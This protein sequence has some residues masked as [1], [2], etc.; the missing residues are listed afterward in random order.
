VQAHFSTS[1]HKYPEIAARTPTR[2][3]RS[4][5]NHDS[6]GQPLCLSDGDRHTSGQNSGLLTM[7]VDLLRQVCV[8][9]SK[10]LNR[11]VQ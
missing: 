11:R 4:E 5:R 3:E 2:E 6:S 1:V 9:R 7:T 10:F 8:A